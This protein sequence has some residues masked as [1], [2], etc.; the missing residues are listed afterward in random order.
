MTLAAWTSTPPP[1][2]YLR[3]SPGPLGRRR[4]RRQPAARPPATEASPA[5][6]TV[7]AESRAVVATAE[8]L[9]AQADCQAVAEACPVAAVA[10]CRAAAGRG[11]ISRF[12]PL[13]P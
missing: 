6:A 1:F 9:G 2:R 5:V 12:G 13:S 11:S 10:P 3:R 7:M 4:Q 8:C